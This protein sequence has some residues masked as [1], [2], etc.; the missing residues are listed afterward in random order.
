M[1][2]PLATIFSVWETLELNCV[3]DSE[4]FTGFCF[5]DIKRNMFDFVKN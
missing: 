2:S 4:S 1:V 5:L 3:L